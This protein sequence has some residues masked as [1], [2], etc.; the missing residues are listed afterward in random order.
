MDMNMVN[1]ESRQ[2]GEPWEY[3]M[4]DHWCTVWLAKAVLYDTGLLTSR[5]P[6]PR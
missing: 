3:G 6:Y 1:H 5:P 4:G 2:H